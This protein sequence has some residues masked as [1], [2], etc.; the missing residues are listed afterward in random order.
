MGTSSRVCV[1]DFQGTQDKKGWCLDQSELKRFYGAS[2]KTS[3][4]CS[5]VL[6]LQRGS[7]NGRK[8][9]CG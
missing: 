7:D 4:M 2:P 3:G 5:Q 9:V 1:D 6:R 8:D